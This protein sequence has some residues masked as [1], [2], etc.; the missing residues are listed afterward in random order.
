MGATAAPPGWQV[1]QGDPDID[2]S[3]SLLPA[4]DGATYV[5]LSVGSGSFSNLTEAIGTTLCAPLQAGVR[6]S[7]CL[8]L[9]IGVRGVTLNLGGNPLMLSPGGPAPVL[10]VF[11]GTTAC[12]QDEPLFISQAIT[13]VDSWSRVCRSFVPTQTLTTLTLIPSLGSSSP[14]S[15]PGGSYVIVDHITSP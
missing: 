12:G 14:T 13:N 7:F 9:A 4:S 3:V 2:P 1:C 8:D 6:Y 10:D 5:G 15:P 11:G